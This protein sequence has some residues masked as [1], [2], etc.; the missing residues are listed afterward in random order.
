MKLIKALSDISTDISLD[1][2]QKMQRLLVLGCEATG[3]PIGIISHIENDTY[4]V[5][6]AHTPDGSIQ[7]GDTFALGDTYCKDTL[8]ANGVVAYHNATKTPG[9]THPCCE[10]F[11]LYSYIG[12]PVRIHNAP[13]GTLNFS[14]PEPSDVPFTDLHYD[15]LTLLAEW[16]GMMISCKEAF[17][18]LM[19]HQVKLEQQNAL[20]NHVCEMASVGAW[21]HII[22][23]GEI[24]WSSTMKKMHG[25]EEDKSI[26]V[27]LASSFPACIADQQIMVNLNRSTIER[28]VPWNNQYEVEL[29]N[30]ERRWFKTYARPVMRNGRCIRIIGSTQD[31]TASVE[32]ENRLRQQREEAESAL[33]VRTG[34]IAN[35]SH[36]L[37]TPINGVMGMLD[38]LKRT[39]LT[40]RQRELT[41]VAQRSA[42]ILLNQVN[43]VLDF[44]KIDAGLMTFVNQP[45]ELNALIAQV[46]LLHRHDAE[47]KGLK[48]E[49]EIALTRGL[50][51]D[52]DV[53]RI[54]QVLTNLLSNAVKFTH[55]GFINVSTR[56]LKQKDNQY[57]VQLIVSDSGIGIDPDCL[58]KILTAFEQG[59]G[60]A[61]RTYGGTGLGLAIVNQIATHYDGGVSVKSNIGGGSTFTVSFQLK[62]NTLLPEQSNSDTPD[63][64]PGIEGLNVLVAEDNPINQLVIE[65]QLTALGVTMTMAD[66]GDQA[67]SAV[68]NAQNT[69]SPFDVII[70]DC[71]MPV[72]DGY[73]AATLIR[74]L[75][76][77]PQHIP[78]IALTAHA[79]AGEREKCLNAGMSDFLTKPVGINELKRCLSQHA[80]R[81]LKPEEAGI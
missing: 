26:S 72:M 45:V 12:V 41:D 40:V 37:R 19:A 24:R 7:S 25:L 8:Q 23:S 31:V 34:F 27:E 69:D 63:H 51:I 71:Q 53:V 22:D 62:Q 32:Y 43:D 58:S 78:I 18:E 65:E 13:Y 75:S 44:S 77:N 3:Q 2:A 66:N 70:M 49:T 29:K 6:A 38:A 21:E 16:L 36:E 74:Q 35:V 11:E 68:V 47:H 56:A 55:T 4:T 46:I 42:G 9:I 14:S 54:K 50:T 59:D 1:A 30:G 64:D 67:L 52:A 15:Y 57:L 61:T 80:G 73:E 28:G 33:K 79:I 10:K 48:L 17:D 5:I 76:G 81:K 20:F 60:S 39:G